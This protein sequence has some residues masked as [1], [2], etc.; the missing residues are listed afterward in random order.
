MLPAGKAAGLIRDLA[1]GVDPDR[2]RERTRGND[3]GR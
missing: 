3:F 2:Q 1:M